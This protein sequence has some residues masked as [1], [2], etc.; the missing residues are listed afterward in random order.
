MKPS[1]MGRESKIIPKLPGALR[2]GET[3][4]ALVL[5]STEMLVG[6]PDADV[7]STR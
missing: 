4:S 3:S 2:N 5:L 7:N 6:N 1:T